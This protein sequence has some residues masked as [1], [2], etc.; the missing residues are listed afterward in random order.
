MSKEQQTFRST[1]NKLHLFDYFSPELHSCFLTWISKHTESINSLAAFWQSSKEKSRRLAEGRV[2]LSPAASASIKSWQQPAQRPALRARGKVGTTFPHGTG[3]GWEGR[4]M[5]AA[6][7]HLVCR[8]EYLLQGWSTDTDLDKER[9]WR[10]AR[11][12]WSTP[13]TE[14]D[15]F[16]TVTI[17]YSEEVLRVCKGKR[18]RD[19]KGPSKTSQDVGI[20]K[21]HTWSSKTSAH[22]GTWL[23]I[24]FINFLKFPPKEENIYIP[25]NV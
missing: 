1:R 20:I 4:F 17:H 23:F 15:K 12:L 5:Q 19:T 9:D 13:S 2:H 6:S 16:F 21:N 8:V 25:W 7:R 11:P 22:E 18:A 24:F 14:Q 3:G 10:R